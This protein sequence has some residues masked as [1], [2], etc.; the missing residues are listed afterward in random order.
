MTF[1]AK[2]GTVSSGSREQPRRALESVLLFW[3]LHRILYLHVQVF[4]VCFF[5]AE[6]S[7][8]CLCT[9]EDNENIIT[10][11]HWSEHRF[12]PYKV[13][14]FFT[15]GQNGVKCNYGNIQE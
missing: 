10:P 8:Y 15:S 3:P 6:N 1:I 13:R 12:L 5:K 9:G 4:L 7:K 2:D 11:A 14:I